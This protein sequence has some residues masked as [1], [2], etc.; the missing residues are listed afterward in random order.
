MR[1]SIFSSVQVCQLCITV[2][3]VIKNKGQTVVTSYV[4]CHCPECGNTEYDIH[5][6][7]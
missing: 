5:K 1:K 4:Y 7:I 6:S 2:G 3:S